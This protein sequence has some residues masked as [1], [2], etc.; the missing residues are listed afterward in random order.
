V[1]PNNKIVSE[2]N[3]LLVLLFERESKL[4]PT[5]W[6]VAAHFNWRTKFPGLLGAFPDNFSALDF[7][8]PAVEELSPEIESHPGYLWLTQIKQT[9]DSLKIVQ[10]HSE[11]VSEFP[12]LLRLRRIGYWQAITLFFRG[13]LSERDVAPRTFSAS[14]RRTIAKQARQLSTSLQEGVGRF[15]GVNDWELRVA[16]ERLAA[17]LE[18]LQKQDS[19]SAD[20]EKIYLLKTL[21]LSLISLNFRNNAPITEIVELMSQAI[22]IERSHRQ[23]QRYVRDA[24]NQLKK[25]RI[26]TNR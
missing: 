15:S 6:L 16:L 12:E 25:W 26:D 8:N 7:E 1:K 4:Q 17:D 20:R 22:D 14:E 18:R 3:G 13:A 5:N 21:A 2:L 9:Q 19:A 10:Q 23:I 11:D 24:S